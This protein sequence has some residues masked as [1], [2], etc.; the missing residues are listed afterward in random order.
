[1]MDPSAP[2]T[3]GAAHSRPSATAIGFDAVIAADTPSGAMDAP[4]AR[5]NAAPLLAVLKA[6]LPPAGT[7]LEIGSG[8]GHH[9]AAFVQELPQHR[10]LPT[11]NTQERRGSIAAWAAFLPTEAPRPLAPRSLDAAADA[12]DWPVADCAPFCAMLSVNVIHIAPWAVALG[13]FAGARRWLPAG[14]PLVLYG[15]FHREG[16][17]MSDGNTTFDASLQR[18]DPSWGIRDL[19]REV[20]PSAGE[21]GLKLAAVHEMPANNL[22]VVLRT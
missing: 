18:Q 21:R 6:E 3:P 8:T 5:R 22:C 12:E 10:W 9:A 20:V 19:E 4:A 2:S 14:A 7:V 11:E 15:P 16:R 17:S 1:M 13:L